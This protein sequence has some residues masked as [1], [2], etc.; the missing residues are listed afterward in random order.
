MNEDKKRIKNENKKLKLLLK[1]I[2]AAKKSIPNLEIT[3]VQTIH[4]LVKY[5]IFLPLCDDKLVKKL[6]SFITDDKGV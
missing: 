2:K 4:I 1:E 6:A 5:D 3:H